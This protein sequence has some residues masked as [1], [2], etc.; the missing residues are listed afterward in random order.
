M[1]KLAHVATR[2]LPT[3]EAGIKALV[4]DPINDPIDDLEDEPIDNSELV[5]LKAVKCAS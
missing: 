5:I 1:R 3:K 4:N 2:L